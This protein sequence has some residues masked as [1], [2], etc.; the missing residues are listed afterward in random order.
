MKKNHAMSL[1]SSWI[2]EEIEQERR[3]EYR[4]PSPF[5]LAGRLFVFMV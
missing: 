3:T 2:E 1:I 5:S 4:A